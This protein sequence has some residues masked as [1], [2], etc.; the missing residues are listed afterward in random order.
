MQPTVRGQLEQ[1]AFCHDMPAAAVDLL[2]GLA[3]L[4]QWGAKTQLFN[5]GD[6]HRWVYLIQTGEAILDMYVPGRGAVRILTVGP[7]D[8][9]GWSPIVGDNTMTTRATTQSTMSAIIFPADALRRLC[10]QDHEIGYHVMRQ[11]AATMSQRLLATRL[12]MLDLF[13]ET[14]PEASVSKG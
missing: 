7:G 12:Q 1:A 3:E 8:F 13:A 10:E 5:E 6:D 4:R 2:A 9:L 14:T 11:V